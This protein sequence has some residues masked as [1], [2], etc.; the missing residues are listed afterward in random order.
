MDPIKFTEAITAGVSPNN[1]SL[2]ATVTHTPYLQCK[3]TP[4]SGHV[5]QVG[6]HHMLFQ[7]DIMGALHRTIEHAWNASSLW[8]AA[9][10]CYRHEFCQSRVAE[11]RLY[12]AF[13]ENNYPEIV[14]LIPAKPHVDVMDSGLCSQE[15]MKCCEEKGVLLKGCHDHRVKLFI[16]SGGRDWLGKGDICCTK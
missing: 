6:H 9:N 2:R 15:E 1:S 4:E 16:D 13:V 10:L 12:F 3:Q 7:R 14:R 11:Y 8:E 5:F